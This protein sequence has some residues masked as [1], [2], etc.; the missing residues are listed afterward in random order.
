MIKFCSVFFI[1][2]YFLS[3]EVLYIFRVVCIESYPSVGD[4]ALATALLPLLLS[5]VRVNDV[6]CLH[7]V[8]WELRF[9]NDKT[10]QN[11]TKQTGCFFIICYNYCGRVFVRTIATVLVSCC[12]LFYYSSRFPCLDRF[13]YFHCYFCFCFSQVAVDRARLWQCQLLLRSQFGTR[14]LASTTD[15]QY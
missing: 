13:E 14:S 3:N 12:T 8:G 11:E 15:S 2:K 7:L 9:D 4:I 1:C 10:K 5:A 6:V